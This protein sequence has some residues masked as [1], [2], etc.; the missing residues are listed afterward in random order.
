MPG[1]MSPRHRMK[2]PLIRPM[3]AFLPLLRRR[4]AS[5]RL[6]ACIPGLSGPVSAGCSPVSWPAPCPWGCQALQRGNRARRI[7]RAINFTGK[8]ERNPANSRDDLGLGSPLRRTEVQPASASVDLVDVDGDVGRVQ[9]DRPAREDAGVDA[10][11]GGTPVVDHAAP[12][13]QHDEVVNDAGDAEVAIQ[14]R[15]PCRRPWCRGTAP[16]R[17]PPGWWRPPRRPGSAGRS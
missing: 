12:G 11:V 13:G 5:G 9:R 10:A 8:P 16:R 17:R 3:P 6:G 15:P 14:F 7:G 1:Y 2:N 4:R